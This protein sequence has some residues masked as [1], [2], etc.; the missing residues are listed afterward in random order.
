MSSIQLWKEVFFV[1]SKLFFFLI[2]KV[3]CF[4]E[5][6]LNIKRQVIYTAY[7]KHLVILIIVKNK[8]YKINLIIYI[9]KLTLVYLIY[10]KIKIKKLKILLKEKL[11]IVNAKMLIN[12]E[13]TSHESWRHD[14]FIFKYNMS[15]D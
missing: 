5:N 13:I 9:D 12:I 3:Q 14:L 7:L 1:L 10:K 4:Y 2:Y 8:Y 6:L 11:L 15:W